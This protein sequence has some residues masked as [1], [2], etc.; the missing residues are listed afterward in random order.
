MIA[1]GG[2]RE[3]RPFLQTRF[4]ERFPSFSPDGRWIAYVSNESGRSEVYVQPYPGP[5]RKWSASGGEGVSP[6][7]G[8]DGRELYYRSGDVLMAVPVQAHP[9]FVP[10]TPRVLFRRASTTAVAA[11]PQGRFLVVDARPAGA[12]SIDVMLNWFTDLKRRITR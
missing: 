4:E 11:G 2:A 1:L 10:G 6:A 8:P 5:G 12:S 3:R 7:W 9:T